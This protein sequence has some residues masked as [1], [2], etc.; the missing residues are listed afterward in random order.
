MQWIIIHL[1]DDDWAL[2]RWVVYTS[3]MGTFMMGVIP[4]GN[5]GSGAHEGLVVYVT[6]VDARVKGFEGASEM[7]SR[8]RCS[9]AFRSGSS[10]SINVDV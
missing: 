10:D 2:S 3:A 5:K 6:T 4:I 8:Y 9:P 7:W 1:S